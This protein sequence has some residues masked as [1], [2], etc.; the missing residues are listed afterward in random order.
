MELNH[1]HI[2]VPDVSAAQRFYEN[3]FGFKLLF[4]HGK[5]VFLSGDKGFLLAIDPLKPEEPQFEFP[6]WFHFGFC[7]PEPKT[8]KELYERMRNEGVQFARELNEFGNDAVNFYCWSPGGYRLEV[9][10]NR[11]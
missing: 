6:A 1:L 3:Y 10:W 5:G 2:N 4:P 7:L 9:S 11:E 8:V